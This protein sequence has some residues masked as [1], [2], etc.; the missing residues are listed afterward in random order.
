LICEE[1]QKLRD[2][3]DNNGIEWHDHSSN[4]IPELFWMCR[5]KFYIKGNEFSV[6]NGIGSYGGKRYASAKN[7]GLLELWIN[8]KGEPQGYL[9]ADN[10]IERI[11]EYE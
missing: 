3:L 9:T 6:I 11:K 4:A 5:T 2:W 7:H 1:M 8:Q 10:V